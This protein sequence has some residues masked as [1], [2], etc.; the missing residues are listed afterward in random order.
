MDP[1]GIPG[2]PEACDAFYRRSGLIAQATHR[3]SSAWLAHGVHDS[4]APNLVA[5]AARD[6][7][8]TD[9]RARLALAHAALLHGRPVHPIQEAARIAAQAT[10]LDADL[11]AAHAGTEAVR[12]R[13]RETTGEF[14]QLGATQRPTFVL[15]NDIGDRAILSGLHRPEP[16]VA[17][18]D[19]LL[20][21][22]L[23][24]ASWQAQYGDVALTAPHRPR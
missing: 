4:A 13:I 24:F 11:L 5:E 19:A 7:G 18:L 14:H 9:D 12:Q 15:E 17:A 22:S 16:L 8:A 23:A 21:D 1:S 6:L 2:S 10:G 3:L 20:A